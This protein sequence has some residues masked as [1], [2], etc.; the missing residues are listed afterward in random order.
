MKQMSVS[1]V[2]FLAFLTLKLKLQVFGQCT[3]H[4]ATAKRWTRQHFTKRNSILKRPQQ[5]FRKHH[6]T[7]K[8]KIKKKQEK[9]HN[10]IKNIQKSK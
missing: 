8:I 7:T 5:Y 4:K 2:L 3:E 10:K 6:K 1:S 9:H